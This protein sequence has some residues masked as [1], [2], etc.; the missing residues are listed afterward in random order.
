VAAK[1]LMLPAHRAFNS[2]GAPEPGATAT[3]YISGGTTPATFYSDPGLTVSMGHTITANAAGRFDPM[4]YQDENVA[5]RLIVQDAEG[6]VL[7]DIDPF[8]FGLTAGIDG[9][10]ATVAIGT[11]TTGAA[12]SGAS[13]VNTG[14]SEIA[15]FDFTIPRGDTGPAGDVAKVTDRTALAAIAGQAVGATRYLV[16][17]GRKGTFVWNSS[18]LSALV[19]ADTQQGIYVP[20]ASDPTGASGAWVRQFDGPAES[21]WFGVATGNTAAANVT[22]YRAA[23]A[24][25]KALAVTGVGYNSG[26]IGLHTTAGHYLFNDKLEN[27]H[28][29]IQSGDYAGGIGGGGGTVFEWT[30][31]G[32]NGFSAPG[33]NG[34]SNQAARSTFKG[35]Y[36]KGA[37]GLDNTADGINFSSA[38]NIED[39]FA[40]GWSRDGFFG[41]SG[42]TGNINDSFFKNLAAQNCRWTITVDGGDGNI[43]KGYGITGVANRAG[44]IND[45]SFLMGRWEGGLAESCGSV[46]GYVTRCESG[47]HIYVVRFGQEAFCAAN[48]P[49]GTTAH[50]TG[51]AYYEEG[52]A[53]ASQPTWSAAQ[54]WQFSAPICVDPTNENMRSQVSG[55]HIEPG[56]NPCVLAQ[57]TMYLRAYQAV[58][59]WDVNCTPHNGVLS[60]ESGVLASEQNFLVGKDLNV[61]G[62]GTVGGLLTANAGLV[63][64]SGFS[65]V[66]SGTSLAFSGGGAPGKLLAGG[67]LAGQNAAST[68]ALTE[69]FAVFNDG[70]NF[71]GMDMGYSSGGYSVRLT[72]PSKVTFGK[73][74]SGSTLQS[75]ITE[76]GSISDTGLAVTGTIVA[77]ST[78]TGSNL[79]GTHSGTS[80]GTN[81]GDQT[82]T[83]TGDVTGSGTGSFAATIANSAVTLAKMANMA[84]A[85]VF[86]RKTAGTGAPEVQTLA[87]LKTDLGLTG[88]NSGDQTITLTGDVTGSGTGSFAAT[89]AAA[90]V[91]YAKIQNVAASRLLGNPTGAPA[92]ASEISLAGG[93]AFSGTTL[94][95][96]GALTPTSVASTGTVT[97]SSSSAGVGYAT[98]AGG[99]VTQLTSKSTGVTLSKTSGQITTNNAALASA[100]V[101]SFTVTNTTVAATDTINLNLQ[102]GNATAGTYRYWIDKVSAGSFVIAVENRSAGSLSEALVFNFAIVK[103][104]NA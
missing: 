51:W 91:T 31:T 39:C 13:V 47:G 42:A 79:S 45:S 80:S 63:I 94:T 95:A 16:E 102:S 1:Q 60:A 58:P 55:F 14:T 69:G 9:N 36:L 2:D 3:L 50:N 28:Q 46:A 57:K 5:F 21:T 92:S 84:T 52:A 44:N 76:W 23:L 29:L 7:D 22:A 74:P 73:R 87:T 78:V 104:V 85:S 103:A 24:T 82:I 19:T 32:V 59:V 37:G 53:S 64:G 68:T 99:T 72:A 90:A 27:T 34:V 43:C 61:T 40:D 71:Y 30:A 38:I 26:S 35:F 8:Y 4:P 41:A 81:T 97:S 88:T 86:Y 11:V 98:G 56:Q 66:G 89:I 12:G 96:A 25:L 49:S 100:A 18:D 6:V 77:T 75:Q 20:P 15:V 65:I 67:W 83:L 62:A 33:Y 17:A 70:S 48:A 54:T 101:V 93:L 10:P